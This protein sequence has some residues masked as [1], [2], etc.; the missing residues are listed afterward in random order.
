M[1]QV[2]CKIWDDVLSVAACQTLVFNMLTGAEWAEQERKDPEQ[3]IGHNRDLYTVW[4]EKTNFLK[5]SADKNYFNSS[6]FLWLDIGA[7]RQQVGRGLASEASC[8]IFFLQSFN[9]KRLVN[10]IPSDSGIL[11]LS[12]ERFTEDEKRLDHGK[13]LADFSKTVRLGGGT[14]GCDRTSLE[15][16]YKAYYATMRSYLERDLFAGK[17]QN[18]MATTCLE[19]DLC[20][21]INANDDNWFKLQDWFIGNLPNENY[22][23]LQ[24][25]IK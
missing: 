15:A 8:R 14:I 16:W 24:L 3:G 23:R 11:L 18:M 17:D 19:T 9:H 12:M 10:R 20:L 7:V 22:Q 2:E 13:S 21:L 6:Y 4:S 25:K 1:R 5:I